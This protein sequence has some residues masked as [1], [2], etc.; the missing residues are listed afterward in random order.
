MRNGKILKVLASNVCCRRPIWT[1]LPLQNVQ[2]NFNEDYIN[3]R[4]A[5]SNPQRLLLGLGSSVMSLVDPYR[6]GIKSHLS[7]NNSVT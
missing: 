6:A 5:V 2:G 1:N 7:E 3:S 4:I